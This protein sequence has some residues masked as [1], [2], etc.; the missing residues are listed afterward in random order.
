MTTP[1]LLSHLY[2]CHIPHARLVPVFFVF[3]LCLIEIK[4]LVLDKIA[5][6]R[7]DAEMADEEQGVAILENTVLR[8]SVIGSGKVVA[9]VIGCA[10]EDAK[11]GCWRGEYK[12]MCRQ[13]NDYEDVNV[14]EKCTHV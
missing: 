14:H 10:R 7:E 8:M 1:K 4:C 13:G 11:G 2:P 9:G 6:D 12:N 5:R 3:F